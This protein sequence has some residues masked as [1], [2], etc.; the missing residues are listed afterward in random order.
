MTLA[1]LNNQRESL[2]L[3]L[4]LSDSFSFSSFPDLFFT[5]PCGQNP[6]VV[7]VLLFLTLSLPNISVFRKSFCTST[8]CFVPLLLGYAHMRA[9]GQEADTASLAHDT[10]LPWPGA[11]PHCMYPGILQ[12]SESTHSA[13]Q[14]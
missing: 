9:A 8:L 11:W 14:L 2:V 5:Y 1:D 6:L 10:I 12:L 4:H 7:F 13:L 3:T